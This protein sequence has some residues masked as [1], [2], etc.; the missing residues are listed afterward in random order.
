[1]ISE[2]QRGTLKTRRHG[3]SSGKKRRTARPAQGRGR[4]ERITAWESLATKAC[5]SG[6]ALARM[7]GVS[8]RHLQ[9]HIR[10]RY[11]T[12][13]GEWLN[14]LR[15]R[16]SYQRLAEGLSIKEATFSLGFKQVSH[17]SRSFKR[18]YGFCPSAVPIVIESE[19]TSPGTG[20]QAEQLK[21]CL[22]QGGEQRRKK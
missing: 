15:L 12:T 8:L 20:S 4:L 21:L 3:K 6:V 10:S 17:F 19:S 1:M 22:F 2:E 9:R 5:Y 7:C 14:A 13:L 18:R 11:A 16:H